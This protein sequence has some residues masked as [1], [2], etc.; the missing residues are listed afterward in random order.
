MKIP[1]LVLELQKFSKE[2]IT[3][4][5]PVN[6]NDIEIFKNKTKLELPNDYIEFL[7]FT[8]GLQLYTNTI[9]G[10]NNPK[11]D[12]YEAFEYEQADSGNPMYEY[13]IPFASDGGGNHYCFDTTKIDLESSV[14]VFWQHDY[15]YS[16]QDS[17]EITNISFSHWVK[18]VLIEWNLENYDYD[19][20]EI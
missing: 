17:P 20:N 11:L 12:L 16:A 5:R 6:L 4:W 8:N 1:E 7:K 2:I 9:Y 14:I 3:F 13:L 15:H 10:I 19:G 18:E